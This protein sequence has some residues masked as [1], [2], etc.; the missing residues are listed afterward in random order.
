VPP[1][2]FFG[3]SFDGHIPQGSVDFHEAFRAEGQ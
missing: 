2:V 1:E 3:L